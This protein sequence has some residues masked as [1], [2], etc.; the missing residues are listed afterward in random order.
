MKR[1][2]QYVMA[3]AEGNPKQA[4]AYVRSVTNDNYSYLNEMPEEHLN[5]FWDKVKKNLLEFEEA[6]KNKK[7]PAEAIEQPAEATA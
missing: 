5:R 2:E 3:V 6:T 7:Q 4:V 1:L